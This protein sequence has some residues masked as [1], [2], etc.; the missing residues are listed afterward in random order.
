MKLND[1]AQNI[2]MNKNI[3]DNLCPKALNGI[4]TNLAYPFVLV[5]MNQ[6]D[7]KKVHRVCPLFNSQK[8]IST[9]LQ[10]NIG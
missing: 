4:D 10:F 1:M 9:P 8:A 6:Y 3:I 7:P 2:T 5:P